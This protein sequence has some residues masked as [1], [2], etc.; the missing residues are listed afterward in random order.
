RRARCRAEARGSAS[1]LRAG[2]APRPAQPRAARP[3][4]RGAA[5]RGGPFAVPGPRGCL[6]RGTGPVRARYAAGRGRTA[7]RRHRVT[8]PPCPLHDPA[9]AGA[10]PGDPR[11]PAL[12]PLRAGGC[13]PPRQPRRSGLARAREPVRARRARGA[14]G[15]PRGPASG[16]PR[17]AP[18]AH[19]R[20]V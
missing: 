19:R 12:R 2:A 1:G 6:R 14:G 7:G 4:R 11:A 18:T 3:P 17:G 20:A 16:A 9:G 15:R 13:D 5:V 8:V 10:P